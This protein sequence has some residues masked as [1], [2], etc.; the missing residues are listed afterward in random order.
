MK[1]NLVIGSNV[2]V[3]LQGQFLPGVKY[4]L[5]GVTGSISGAFNPYAS[6]SEGTGLSAYET[7]KIQYGADPFVFVVPQLNLAPAA[8]TP[9]QAA[10]ANAIANA[11]GVSPLLTALVNNNAPATVPSTLNALSGEGISGQ[12]QTALNAGNLFVTTVLSQ[13]TYF[14]DLP[15]DPLGLKDGA[16]AC[17]LK[18][19]Y[20]CAIASRVRFW[21]AGFGGEATLNAQASTG[22]ASLS[23]SNAGTAAGLDVNVTR[24][25]LLGLAAGYSDSTFTVPDRSTT[26]TVEGGHFALYSR[27]TWNNVYMAGAASYA[28]YYNTTDR[29]VTGLGPLEEERGKFSSGE[30]LARFE[31]GYR[32]RH[33]SVNVTPFAGFQLASLSNSAF[34]EFQHGAGGAF[35]CGENSRRQYSLCWRPIRH[36]AHVA[37]GLCVPPLSQAVI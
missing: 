12:Q 26:G 1:G 16:P 10:V 6:F 5:I 20:D 11:A 4:D 8:Q 14:S 33:A 19:G 24:T 31:G 22:A 7:A 29:F 2:Q 34:I 9:N 15:G 18:D 25:L 27:E 28:H 30:W 13:A 21:A 32:T 35:R 36:K 17:S 23:S 37:G 3:L